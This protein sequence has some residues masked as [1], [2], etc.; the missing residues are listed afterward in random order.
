M[1]RRPSTPAQ[2]GLP[3]PVIWR[4]PYCNVT[5]RDRHYRS[6]SLSDWVR[7]RAD[8]HLAA[9]ASA[10]T[11]PFDSDQIDHWLNTDNV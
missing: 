8:A 4:C 5:I 2:P 3:G 1:N 11:D 6:I 9:H 10:M 7:P